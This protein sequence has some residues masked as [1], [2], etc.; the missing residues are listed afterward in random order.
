MYYRYFIKVLIRY[1]NTFKKHYAVVTNLSSTEEEAKQ[2]SIE[3]VT[4]WKSVVSAEAVKVSRTPMRIYN[5]IVECVL[6]YANGSFKKIYFKTTAESKEDAEHSFR[7]EL[8]NWVNV[9]GTEIIKI[10][11]CNKQPYHDRY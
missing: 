2:R 1:S 4:R 8:G 9:V 3:M 6:K 10:E 11:L 5:Y 7:D